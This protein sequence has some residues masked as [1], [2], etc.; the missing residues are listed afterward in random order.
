MDDNDRYVLIGDESELRFFFDYVMPPLTKTEVF[1]L[2]LSARNKLLTDEEKERIQLGRTEMF[3][4]KVVRKK[5]WDR[6]YR[7]IKKMETATG[8][9]T[10]KNGSNI[11]S[12]AIM[13]YFNVNPSDSLKAY[14]EFNQTMNE[15]MF[16]LGQCASTGSDASNVLDRIKKQDRLLMNCYQKNR[17]TRYWL[18]FDFD[19]PKEQY[20]LNHLYELVYEVQK[21]NGIAYIIETQGGYHVLVSKDTKFDKNFNPKTLIEMMDRAI[22]QE[23]TGVNT[24]S[25]KDLG[26]EIIHN[27]NEMV[28]IPGTYHYGKVVRILNKERGLTNFANLCSMWPSR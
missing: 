21:R 8:S 1:F 11:P 16:E 27:K 10:T 25:L 17:G 24:T 22:A 7:T 2:S 19:I 20:L 4:R 14:R 23:I 28:A 18:D 12:H 3:S 5:E 6:F 13:C 26:Y 9:Y 15:Y